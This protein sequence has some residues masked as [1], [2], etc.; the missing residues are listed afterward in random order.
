MFRKTEKKLATAQELD[1][2]ETFEYIPSKF[3]K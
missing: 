1:P 2:K 3:K